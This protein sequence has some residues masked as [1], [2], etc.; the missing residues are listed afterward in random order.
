MT[1]FQELVAA[2][3]R[4]IGFVRNDDIELLE[5]S[6]WL[7]SARKWC[8]ELGYPHPEDFILYRYK[9][10]GMFIFAMWTKL[11]R[12]SPD[13]HGRVLGIFSMPYPPGTTKFRGLECPDW[14][15]EPMM[16]YRLRPAR[17]QVEEAKK[18]IFADLSSRKGEEAAD[19][20]VETR[21]IKEAE[22][23]GDKGLA[24]K[25]KIGEVKVSA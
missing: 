10:N 5:D 9:P 7:K 25:V 21:F 20:E 6:P 11:P 18:E 4:G 17:A 13:G 24:N 2:E 19:K 22:A 12:E 1:T 3:E 14:P 23:R 15:N 16:K 8:A